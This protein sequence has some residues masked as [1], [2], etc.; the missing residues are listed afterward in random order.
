VLSVGAT[1]Q[2]SD[3]KPGFSNYGVTVDVFAPG[4]NILST[5]PGDDY[6]TGLGTSMAAPM[7]SGLAGLVKT[8]HPTWTNDQVGEQVRVTCDSIDA[9]NPSYA[10]RL[11]K[12]RINAHRAVTEEG[13]PSIRIAGYSYT[14]SDGDSIISPGDTVDVSVGFINYLAGTSDIA[15]QL[16]VDDTLIVVLNG[17]AVI[18]SL[19]TDEVDSVTF[20]FAVDPAAP[21]GTS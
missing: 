13:N 4:V 2:S 8:L 19:A 18:P 15:V 20:Q 14:E 7:V 21:E 10:G 1:Q 5:V 3:V 12:G 9:A 11:G 16:T 6:D 17:S